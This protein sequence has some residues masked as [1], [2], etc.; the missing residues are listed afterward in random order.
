MPAEM[1]N[2]LKSFFDVSLKDAY[3]EC[4]DG[5]VVANRDGTIAFINRKVTEIFGYSE[6]ELLG[7]P[8]EVL[9]PD[10]IRER[11]VSFRQAYIDHPRSRPMGMDLQIKGRHVNGSEL[12]LYV[13][14]SY[15][16]THHGILAVAYV[17]PRQS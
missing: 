8:I 7:K 1:V 11:H 4:P 17:R 3:A 13:S 16:G 10:E 15:V 9:V 12:Q 2:A 5:V 6:P 14:L